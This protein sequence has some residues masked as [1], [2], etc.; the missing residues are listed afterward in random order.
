MFGPEVLF[1][2]QPHATFKLVFNGMFL[3]SATQT[4]M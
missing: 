1:R 2:A 4:G 3:G